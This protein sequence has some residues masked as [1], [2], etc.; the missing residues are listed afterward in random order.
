MQSVSSGSARGFTRAGRRRG[1][2]SALAATSSPSR[3]SAAVFTV[4]MCLAMYATTCDADK[5]NAMKS[6]SF[7]ELEQQRGGTLPKSMDSR[8]TRRRR[9]RRTL[10]EDVEDGD[11]GYDGSDSG[12]GDGDGDGG[13]S[14]GGDGGG[15]DGG[16]GDGDGVKAN[17]EKEG[18]AP[19]RGGGRMKPKSGAP[20]LAR[21]RGGGGAGRRRKGRKEVDYDALV[22]DATDDSVKVVLPKSPG[23]DDVPTWHPSR[24]K[25]RREQ[26]AQ[27]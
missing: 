23:D 16:G 14:G 7:H 24:S 25:R 17:A 3:L 5:A 26:R 18:N 11:G 4:T 20:S 21:R 10:L 6:N 19:G 1:D 12:G 9:R 13:G 8:T 22:G 2:G 27:G 15:G